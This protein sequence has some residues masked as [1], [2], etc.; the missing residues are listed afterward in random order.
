[1]NNFMKILTS[2]LLCCAM[3]SPSVTAFAAEGGGTMEELSNLTGLNGSWTMDSVIR[4]QGSGDLFALSQT[5]VSDFV[6]EADVEFTSHSGAA[7]LVFFSGDNPSKGSYVANIDLSAGNARIFRFEST[8]NATTKGEYILSSSQKTKNRFNLRVEAQNGKL[9]YLIDGTP[10]ISVSDSSAKPGSKLGLLTYNTGIN[11]SNVRYASLDESDEN[12]PRLSSLTGNGI[13]FDGSNCLKQT[14]PYGTASLRY[15]VT[16]F[17]SVSAGIAG[18]TGETVSVSGNTVTVGQISGSFDLLLAV[19]KGEVVRHYWIKVTVEADP[20]TIYNEQWR[21]QLHFSPLVNWMNDPNGLVY[22]PTTET[23]HLF[24]QYNPY[25][26]TIANQVWGHAVS[27]DLVH[28]KELGV[29]IEQ[30]S[31]GA[32]FSGSAVVDEDNTTGFFTDNKPGETKLVAIYT[33]DG[34]D[35]T[36]GVEKQCI[37]YSKDNGV[38]WIKP[39]LEENGFENPIIANDNNVYGRDF[40]D[41]KIFRYDGKWFMVVAGGRARLF[42]SDNLIDWTMVCD[43]GFD[44]ECPDF[45]PLAVDG[46]ENNIKWVYTAS[47]KWY[48]IGRLEKVSETEYKFVAEGDRIPYNGGS[49]VYA[50]QSYYND[51]SGNNRRIAISW[52]QDSSA[53]GLSG[54]GWNGAM[55][56]PYEQTLRTVNGRIILTSYPVAEVDAQRSEKVIDLEN[57]SIDEAGKALSGNP[58]IAYDT[59]I[60][61]TP[62]DGSVLQLDLR[63]DGQY[64]TSLVYDS[65]AHT[66]RVVR[67]RSGSASG[68]P[69]GTMEMPLYPDEDGKVTIRILMDTTVL[70][71]F[72]NEGE[73]ALC[74]MIFPEAGAINT[75]L[76]VSG[77]LAIDS[78]EMWRME[79]IWHSDA[80]ILPE[81]GVYFE[82]SSSAIA[83]EEATTVTAYVMDQNGN[84]T[85]KAV[86][87][88]GAEDSLV[89][90]VSQK[91][92]T[93]VLQGIQ[94][95]SVTLRA[96]VDGMTASITLP[97]ADISFHTNLEGWSSN[98]DWYVTTGG[99]GISGSNGDSFAFSSGK[100]SG[101][102]V[103]SGDADFGGQG[104][105]LGLVFAVTNPENPSSGTWYGA[106]IDTHSAQPVMKLFC[107]T[108]GQEVWAKTYTFTK[109]ADSWNLTVEYTEDG[110]LIYTVNGQSVSRKVANLGSGALGLVSWNGGG[111]FDNVN[112][113]AVDVGGETPDDDLGETTSVTEPVTTPVIGSQ[114][115][116]STED[117]I[118][119]DT[120]KPGD[121]TP[122]TGVKWI[123]PTVLSAV[124]VV[125]VA[126]VV[127]VLIVRKK[128]K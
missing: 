55:T 52:I 62:G 85:D 50:T 71:V 23:Y 3:L 93:I 14:V 51:G 68:V 1:M 113:Q 119:T 95:G 117:P 69:A 44:S 7:S 90:T 102:F 120:D 22:D 45:Y 82:V 30:D 47:G 84:R 74:G 9:L 99:Y 103:Y 67:G 29:A 36:H 97:V 35:T 115:D 54:K 40:R 110:T 125:A 57:V 66:L 24:F 58:G 37:A 114:S 38:T 123:L 46:D 63:S 32:V 48:V 83:F 53:S 108:N 21:P 76:S 2:A 100:N 86:S 126:A 28:W 31:L 42:I 124:S 19:T 122:S 60:T 111:C 77:D 94:E 121:E 80:E 49:E 8:G 4:S 5:E 59:V 13:S 73:A 79:S 64:A 89:K 109:T 20:D 72:G 107:N 101:T 88:S 41:P 92:G 127:T 98:G 75:I 33:S 81:P 34:G 96:T 18:D 61:F 65:T 15:Q 118:T 87:W 16:A 91:D 10:V 105:C 116:P 112:Y 39:T 43:M 56:L 6:F 26:L 70:E 11:Y 17:G 128:K 106:N 104:G 12:V 78:L 25:G 27:T